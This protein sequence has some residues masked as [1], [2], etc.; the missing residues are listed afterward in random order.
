MLAA[1]VVVVVAAL[2]VTLSASA[3]LAVIE[4]QG[5]DGR[6]L[7]ARDA[8]AAGLGAALAALRRD[9][10]AAS[11]DS[12][13]AQG[14]ASYAVTAHP[15]GVAGAW[16]SWYAVARGS[17]GHATSAID[18]LVELRVPGFVG[19]LV[20]AG[21][22]SCSAP[23][24]LQGCGVR[25]AGSFSGREWVSFASSRSLP[26][27]E[28]AD[29]VWAEPWPACGVHA[30]GSIWALGAEI[31]DGPNRWPADTDVHTGAAVETPPAPDVAWLAQAA[32]LSA[33]VP[34][35]DNG[36]IE[37]TSIPPTES[38]AGKVVFLPSRGEPV[39]LAGGST[40]GSRL[41]VVVDGDCRI[42]SPAS[43]EGALV[44]RGALEVLAT[45]SVTGHVAAAS[46]KVDAPMS[47][48]LGP[49][50]RRA[51]LAGVAGPVI[52]ALDTR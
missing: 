51:P 44:V 13:G 29:L 22:V 47:I 37:L 50:W 43:L 31:H 48:T 2:A 18:A 36:T 1:L 14:Q 5:S 12:T 46:L 9:P 7:Q 42:T 4:V 11:V 23:L 25:C 19:G 33:A 6:A 17:L 15:A 30:T 26:T 21:D 16:P 20:A 10:A 35:A 3:A 41:V 45:L 8:A 39:L 52:V 38:V 34:V 32:E 40:P 27:G 24:K 28:P 49:E